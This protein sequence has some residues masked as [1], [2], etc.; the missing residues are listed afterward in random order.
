M[1]VKKKK[2]RPQEAPSPQSKPSEKA[3]APAPP[4]SATADKK[5][6]PPKKPKKKKKAGRPAWKVTPKILEEAAGFAALGLGRDDIA[7]NLGVAPATLYAR[8]AEL[9]E[10]LE[11]IEG[12]KAAAKAEIKGIVYEE[13]R[14]RI[15]WAI[16]SWLRHND[17]PPQRVTLEGNPDK[18]LTFVG[19]SHGPVSSEKAG[20]AFAILEAARERKRKNKKGGKTKAK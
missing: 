1:K 12:G 2:K 7:R 3:E 18:P 4:V 6:D 17:P 20:D 5:P 19:R 15:P 10:L 16:Q 14:K 11:A 13:A 8:L 9:P